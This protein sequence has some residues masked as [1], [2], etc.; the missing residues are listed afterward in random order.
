MSQSV[1][2]KPLEISKSEKQ[3]YHDLI[4]HNDQVIN[5]S[6]I[7]HHSNKKTTTLQYN[8]FIYK[9]NPK[10]TNLM[11]FDCKSRDSGCQAKLVYY[12][13]FNK[14]TQSH[15]HSHAPPKYYGSGEVGKLCP[16]RRREVFDWLY[17]NPDDSL[18]VNE[19]VNVLNSK[20]SPLH[21]GNPSFEV[22]TN[23]VESA[24]NKIKQMDKLLNLDELTKGPLAKT[25]SEEEFLR[26]FEFTPQFNLFYSS[27]AQ[28]LIIKIAQLEQLN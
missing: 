11:E 25:V 3:F 9:E 14:W 28:M 21:K 17:S 19:V 10:L 7:Q 26:T 20:L 4:Q 2:A 5:Q 23:H 13:Q 22:K 16:E 1:N 27:P 18:D 15:D 8:E 12:P 6:E 24:R